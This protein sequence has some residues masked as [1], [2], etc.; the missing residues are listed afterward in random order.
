MLERSIQKACPSSG[1][2]SPHELQESRVWR[3]AGG[4]S[5]NIYC[6][7]GYLEGMKVSDLNG[8][9]L[10]QDEGFRYWTAVTSSIR[11]HSR[12]VFMIGNGASAS[13]A[14]H[15][16]AD[17]AKNGRLHTEVFSDLSLITAIANDMGYDEVFAE[18]LRRRMKVGDMLVAV[19]SSGNSPNVLKAAQEARRLGGFVVT[20]TAMSSGNPLRASGDLNFYVSAHTYGE[21]ETCHAAI[22]HHWM[23]YLDLGENAP[24]MAG[25]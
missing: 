10:E 11:E 23:D 12:C 22:L 1:Q 25:Y 14:S 20:L 5:R 2:P 16:S 4:W 18:P 8:Q 17:L 7:T 3:L 9:S 19:S 6:L 21:A 24:T 13:M 15:I